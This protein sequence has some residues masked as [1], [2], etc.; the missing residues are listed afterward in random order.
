M[1]ALLCYVSQVRLWQA[2]YQGPTR[3]QV[4][5]RS[6]GQFQIGHHRG[7]SYADNLSLHLKNLYSLGAESVCKLSRYWRD[8]ILNPDTIPRIVVNSEDNT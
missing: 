6:C 4:N 7:I 2:L 1:G 5:Y 3:I 8:K